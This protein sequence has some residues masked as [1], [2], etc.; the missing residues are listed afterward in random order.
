MITDLNQLSL[1]KIFASNLC[2][3]TKMLKIPRIYSIRFFSA[4]WKT[5]FFSLSLSQFSTPWPA[6]IVL[7]LLLFQVFVTLI[8][9][10]LRNAFRLMPRL[11]MTVFAMR[12]K[13]L[14]KRKR[15]FTLRNQTSRRA[16]P[17]GFHD[18]VWGRALQYINAR[19]TD[20]CTSQM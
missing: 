1:I 7:M 8:A 11:Y 15:F 9:S 10:K 4:E 5:L 6:C 3:D 14:P 2:V 13:N 12:N 20:S 17:I 19:S 16:T 18:Q